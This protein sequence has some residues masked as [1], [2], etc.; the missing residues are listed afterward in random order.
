MIVWRMMLIGL[1][2]LIC[3]G[4]ERLWGSFYEDRPR[5]GG[6]DCARHDLGQSAACT[7]GHDMRTDLKAPGA[8]LAYWPLDGDGTD[9]AGGWD[10]KLFG[11]VGF[12]AGILGQAL[13]LRGIQS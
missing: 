4:C 12:T 5:D 7:G 1:G 13:D 8:L 3:T 10:L 2:S 11:G 6:M 9:V